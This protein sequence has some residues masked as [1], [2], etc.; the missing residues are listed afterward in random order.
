MNAVKR[1][2]TT[3]QVETGSLHRC[4]R[5]SSNGFLGTGMMG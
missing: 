1:V 3:N 2:F 5:V 4:S